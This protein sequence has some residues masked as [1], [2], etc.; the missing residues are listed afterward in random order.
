[1]FYIKDD[2]GNMVAVK[3]IAYKDAKKYT[4]EV[5]QQEECVKGW[6]GA[7]NKMYWYIS[8][9]V[10]EEQFMKFMDIE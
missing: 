4:C 1:M 8:K 2:E 10:F 7:E 5:L 9:D 3:R 6:L